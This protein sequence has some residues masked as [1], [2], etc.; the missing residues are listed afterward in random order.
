MRFSCDDTFLRSRSRFRELR[1]LLILGPY[2][3]KHSYI[4]TSQSQLDTFGTYTTI[5]GDLLVW[6]T[7]ATLVFPTAIHTIQGRLDVRGSPSLQSINASNLRTIENAFTLE[8]VPALSEFTVTEITVG[9][10]SI[11]DVPSLETWHGNIN[12]KGNTY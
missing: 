10:L 12:V 3:S 5:F 2:T 6:C 4:V 7:D 9:S 8:H 11:Q 1:Q